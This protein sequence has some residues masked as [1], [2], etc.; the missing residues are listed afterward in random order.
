M[1][2]LVE[3]RHWPIACARARLT[4]RESI[5]IARQIAAALEAAHEK[6]II[7]RDLKPANVKLA[8]GDGAV[9]L[10]DFGLVQSV[11]AKGRNCF[12][13]SPT[14][15]SDGT[16]AGVVLGTAAYMSPEQARGQTVDKRTDIWSFGCVLYEMLAGRRPFPGQTISRN[17]CGHHRRRARLDGRRRQICRRAFRGSCAGASRRISN[18][19]FTTLR[20]PASSWTTS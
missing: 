8:S 11:R 5:T 20:T 2:E 1:L 16:R 3:D 14:L 12:S 15:T 7:H 4:A 10:L 6:G 19:V 17:R 18:G 9:K 13:Q